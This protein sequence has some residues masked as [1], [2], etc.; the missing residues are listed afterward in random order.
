MQD[1]SLLDK[2]Q[3][4]WSPMQVIKSPGFKGSTFLADFRPFSGENFG[5]IREIFAAQY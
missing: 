4:L 5:N 2:G 3:I 1:W